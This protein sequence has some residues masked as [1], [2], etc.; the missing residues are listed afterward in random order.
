MTSRAS[1]TQARWA[2]LFLPFALGYYLSYFLRNANAVIAPVLTRELDLSAA[3]L[4]LLT[5][6]Y[7]FTFG[8]FQIP[9]GMLLDRYGSRRVEALLMLFA[10]AGTLTFALGQGIVPLAIGRGLIGVGV[11]G[12]LMAALKHFSQ[13]YPRERQSALTGAIMA[14][15]GL[16]AITASVPMEAVLPILGWRGVFLAITGIIVAVAALIFFAVPDRDDASGQTTLASQWQGVARIFASRDFW[17]FAP[18]MALFPG[19]F[20]AVTGL[21][22]VPWFMDVDGLSRESAA[23]SLFLLSTM[24]LA[25]YF[26]IAIFATQLTRRGLK[27]SRLIGAAL[28]VAWACAVLAI[29]GIQPALPFWVTYSF[30][31][32]TAPLLYAALGTYFPSPLFGRVTTALNL[33]AF[34]GAFSLQWGL[35]VLVDA[36]VAADWPR[37]DAFRAAFAVMAALQLLAWVWFI[38]GVDAQQ[39]PPDRRKSDKA[40]R[41]SDTAVISD[42]A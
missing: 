3:D 32:S 36:F 40:N 33:L 22:I 34:V 1:T 30:F 7:F 15:G 24:Q 14:A 4:G 13:W 31:S 9:L 20:M 2:R 35:G 26:A 19:G 37:A 27:L 21:W 6:A 16:G 10:A 12:C 41:G 39:Q 23:Y 18:L 5:S 29:A 38:W 8:A 11:S 25:S 42:M 17:R 28:A